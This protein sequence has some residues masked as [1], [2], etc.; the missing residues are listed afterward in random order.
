MNIFTKD[1][2]CPK[3]FRSD[4]LV[5]F[6]TNSNYY[7]SDFE[8]VMD[9]KEDLRAWSNS[10]WPEDS[11]TAEENCSD[12]KL[13]EE[14]NK[15]HDAYGYMLYTPDMKYCYG[16]V[17]V[18]PLDLSYFVNAQDYEGI[19]DAR[20]DFWLRSNLDYELKLN[21]TKYLTSWLDVDWKIRWF[22]TSRPNMLERSKLYEALGLKKKYELTYLKGNSIYLYNNE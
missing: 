7:L 20:V 2:D 4:G 10:E 21:I 17:Y 22:F 19:V 5:C 3:G 14:D 16:S 6:P 9:S 18:N 1:F 15:N 12:L 11:F 13:H 8:A